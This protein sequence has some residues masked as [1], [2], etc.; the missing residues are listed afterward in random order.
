MILTASGNDLHLWDAATGLLKRTFK[1]H[2]D[3]VGECRF[4]LTGRPS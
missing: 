1:G 4:F 3:V 2:I